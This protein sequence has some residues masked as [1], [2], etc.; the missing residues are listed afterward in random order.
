[1]AE[2]LCALSIEQLNELSTRL[3]EM[4][5]A[6]RNPAYSS[7]LPAARLAVQDLATTR[8][9]IEEIVAEMN[10]YCDQVGDH[11]VSNKVFDFAAELLAALG[12]GEESE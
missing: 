1:M 6:S 9:S 4:S 2:Q 11:G 8:F 5:E 7:D 3:D 10:K 12:Y